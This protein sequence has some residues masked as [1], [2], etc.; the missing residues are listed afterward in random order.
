V[1][2]GVREGAA[3]NAGPGEPHRGSGGVGCAKKGPE[4]LRLTRERKSQAGG[5]GLAGEGLRLVGQG[6]GQSRAPPATT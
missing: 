6:K 5:S 2:L 3:D 4:G 1:N